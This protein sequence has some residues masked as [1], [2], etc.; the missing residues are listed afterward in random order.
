MRPHTS[1]TVM[2]C[3]RDSESMSLPVVDGIVTITGTSKEPCVG[4][5][6]MIYSS[7]KDCRTSYSQLLVHERAWKEPCVGL[8]VMISI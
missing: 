5:D 2:S 6:V 3:G 1:D 4:L 7:K 8:D